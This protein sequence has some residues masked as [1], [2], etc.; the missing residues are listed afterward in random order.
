MKSSRVNPATIL[1][2]KGSQTRP[3]HILHLPLLVLDPPPEGLD[4]REEHNHQRHVLVDPLVEGRL[5][6]QPE[7]HLLAVGLQLFILENEPFDFPVQPVVLC[8]HDKDTFSNSD[9]RSFL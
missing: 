1:Q 3:A 7:P 6:R 5:I 4:L 8:Y 9:S 2:L